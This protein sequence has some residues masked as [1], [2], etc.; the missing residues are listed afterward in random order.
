M[1][2]SISGPTLHTPFPNRTLRNKAYTPLCLLW[3]CPMNPSRWTTCQ[4]FCQRS[5]EMTVFLWWLIV[6]LKWPFLVPARRAS[7]KRPLPRSSSNECGYILGYH[8]PSSW[9]RRFGFSTYFGR[10]YGHFWTPRSPNPLPS[11]PKWMAKLRSSTR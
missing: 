11:T 2:S 3:K 9:I 7:Q 10:A 6:L 1:S 8:K 4:A 5:R